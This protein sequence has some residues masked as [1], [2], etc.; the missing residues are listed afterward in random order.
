MRFPMSVGP[1]FGRWKFGLRGGRSVW[2]R[3]GIDAVDGILGKE[4][5]SNATQRM[6]F[7]RVGRIF[8]TFGAISGVHNTNR[9]VAIVIQ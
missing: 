2:W 3:R 9:A 4:P 8:S 7:D 6:S 1:T 5:H